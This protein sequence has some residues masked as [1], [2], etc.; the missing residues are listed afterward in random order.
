MRRSSSPKTPKAPKADP[1]QRQPGR[2]NET[3]VEWLSPS[4]YRFVETRMPAVH[5]G[6]GAASFVDLANQLA[7]GHIANG[8][9]GIAVCGAAAGAGVSFLASNLAVAMAAAGVQTRLVEAN[10]RNP[11]LS[12]AI[13]PIVSGPGLAEYLMDATVNL[14]DVLNAEIVPNL[15]V[16]FAGAHHSEAADLL[17]TQRFA[18]FAEACLRDAGFT[19]FDTAPANRAVDARV[20]AKAAGYALLVARRG[21]SF[22]EDVS[23][24]SE[25]LA[26]DRVVVVGTVLN[27]G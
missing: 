6:A 23:M 10:L 18:R 7:A 21:R 8:R 22:H 17:T 19:I 5:A 1:R 15:D 11:D 16:I 25:Q 24:L 12:E 2:G 26:Q 27:R 9:R 4:G 20:V 14:P 13:R 3:P